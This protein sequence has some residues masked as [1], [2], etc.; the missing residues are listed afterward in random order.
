MRAEA[1]AQ[2]R[3]GPADLHGLKAYKSVLLI[4]GERNETARLISQSPCS[5]PEIQN[6]EV[7]G[8]EPQRHGRDQDNEGKGVEAERERRREDRGDL[9]VNP[10]RLDEGVEAAVGPRRAVAPDPKMLLDATDRERR[11]GQGNSHEKAADDHP[12]RESSVT[13]HVGIGRKEDGYFKLVADLEVSVPG[14]DRAAVEEMAQ[15]AHE[16]VC[17]YSRATRGNMEVNVRVI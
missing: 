4:G 1:L 2:S 5:F 17:P 7:H 6:R 15:I 8:H 14:R 13:A 10:A 3:S 12:I 16:E 11:H 9:H